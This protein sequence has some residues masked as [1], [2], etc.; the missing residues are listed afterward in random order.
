MGQ[1]ADEAKNMHI[2]A[3]ILPYYNISDNLSAY[4]N[5]GISFA[6]KSDALDEAKTNFFVNPYVA[7]KSGPG[8]FYAGFQLVTIAKG[9]KGGNP[10]PDKSLLAWG[11]PIGMA[12]SF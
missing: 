1:F 6:K 8:T 4:L 5:A 7:V 12:V 11:V 9:L 2:L 10:D 3:D